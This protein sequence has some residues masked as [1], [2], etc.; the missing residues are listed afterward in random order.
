[1]TKSLYACCLVLLLLGLPG[2]VVRAQAD[3]EVDQLRL[4]NAALKARVEQLERACPAVGSAAAAPAAQATASST[5][6][7]AVAAPAIP[8]PASAAG[9]AASAPAATTSPVSPAAVAVVAPPAPPQAPAGYKLVK[10]DPIASAEEE[11]NCSHGMFVNT[12]DS[13]WKHEEN[14]TALSKQM[15]PSQV[16]ALLG[17]THNSVAKGKRTMWQ[18]GK[19]GTGTLAQAFVVFDSDGLLFWQQPDY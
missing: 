4:Q 13:P 1:M 6:N 16:E 12:K 18:F 5:A 3:G 11:E 19:C 10:I 8:A 15:S 17:K 2:L 7:A 9:P 14:W